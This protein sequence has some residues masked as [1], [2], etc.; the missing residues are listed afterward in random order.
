MNDYNAFAQRQYPA[1]FTGLLN[2][3]EPRTH[4]ESVLRELE[5]AHRQLG[6]RGIYYGLDTLHDTASTSHS[7]TGDLIPSGP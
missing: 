5:R 4:T 3:D 6:L 1:K 2:V 7:M